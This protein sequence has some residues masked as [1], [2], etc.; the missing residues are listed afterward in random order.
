MAKL[1]TE[2]HGILRTSILIPRLVGGT[3]LLNLIKHWLL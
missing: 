2:L 3:S 1:S